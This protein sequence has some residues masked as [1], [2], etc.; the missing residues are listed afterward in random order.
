[1]LPPGHGKAAI[2]GWQ[3]RQNKKLTEVVVHAAKLMVVL[4]LKAAA[5]LPPYATGPI[6]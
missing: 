2:A 6:V 1:V 4:D 5:M 3:K